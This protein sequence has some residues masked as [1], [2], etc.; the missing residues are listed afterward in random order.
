M[1]RAV[2]ASLDSSGVPMSSD[3]RAFLGL[4]IVI[5]AVAALAWVV[6][7]LQAVGMSSSMMAMMAS[8][9]GVAGFGFFLLLW[10]VMM[11]AM[12][13]PAAAP[14][15][16]AFVGLSTPAG[17]ARSRWWAGST[18]LFL[19]VYL[20]AWA[21]TGVAVALAYVVLTPRVAELGTDGTLGV[22]VAGA[23]LVVAGI[24]QTTPLKQ[25]CLAGCRSPLS[26]LLRYWRKGVRGTVTLGLRHASY[27]LGCC[28]LL[29]AVLFTVGVM[30]LP[31]MAFLAAVIF[32]EK[33]LPVG[34]W[35]SFAF[36]GLFVALGASFLL[37]PLWGSYA[38]GIS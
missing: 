23:V 10:S 19:G 20:L 21:A 22:A 34:H 24:Y 6:T 36:G 1:G 9:S 18:A 38:L 11:V 15:V 8:A 13:F 37:F 16:R 28:A 25:T 14:M 2:A 35:A 26:F 30:A 7:G 33:A 4:L 3:R 12:M 27:C 5:V 29:F 32:V 17:Q 31:W